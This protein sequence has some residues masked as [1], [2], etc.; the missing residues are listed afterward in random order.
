MNEEFTR[1]RL[2]DMYLKEFKIACVEDGH[3][4]WRIKKEITFTN[5]K[6]AGIIIIDEEAKAIS[7]FLNNQVVLEYFEGS[8]K[9]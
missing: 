3:N 9:K 7:N 1:V 6:E 5:D 8:D 4:C 2:G